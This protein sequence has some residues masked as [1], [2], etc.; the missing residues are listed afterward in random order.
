MRMQGCSLSMSINFMKVR[1]D[2]QTSHDAI[3]S[4]KPFAYLE[5]GSEGIWFGP[6]DCH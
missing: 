3:A 4:L 1:W 2:R 6:E 5:E